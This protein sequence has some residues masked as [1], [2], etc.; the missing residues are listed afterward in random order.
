MTRRIIKWSNAAMATTWLSLA[1]SLSLS[2][3]APAYAE[4]DSV[5]SVELRLEGACDANNSKLWLINN[6]TTKTINATLRWSLANSKRVATDQFQVVPGAKVEI[7]CAAKADI[8][9]AVYAEP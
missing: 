7:G 4:D 5:K 1:V 6:H 2:L 8:V 3:A 9:S